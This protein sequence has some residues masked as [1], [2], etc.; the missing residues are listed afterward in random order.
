[1]NQLCTVCV[2]YNNCAC[3]CIYYISFFV[4]GQLESVLKHRS[5]IYSTQLMTIL[6]RRKHEIRSQ[7]IGMRQRYSQ[8]SKDA[9]FDW[10]LHGIN[11]RYHH[12]NCY[13]Q[14]LPP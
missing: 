10:L 5:V 13:G 3:I 2:D 11:S 1:M 14:S 7:L 8:P 12:S 4:I 6:I 9:V